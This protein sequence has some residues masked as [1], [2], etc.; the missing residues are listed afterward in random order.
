LISCSPG[1]LDCLDILSLLAAVASLRHAV[2]EL[3][4][5]REEMNPKILVKEIVEDIKTLPAKDIKTIAEFVDFIKEKELEEEILASNKI[6]REV[7]TSKKDWKEKK[8][9]EFIAW[10]DLKKKFRL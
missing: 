3:R 5:R 4:E 2:I 8:F 9:A 1:I 10:E 7:K 6:V